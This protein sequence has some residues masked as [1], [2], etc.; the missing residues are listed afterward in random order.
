M[1]KWSTFFYSRWFLVGG[2]I[3]IVFLVFSVGRSFYQQN[4]IAHQIAQLEMQAKEL[5]TKKLQTLELLQYARSTNFVEE[6]ARTELHLMKPGEH[7]MVVKNQDSPDKNRQ[8]EQNMVSSSTLSN[9]Q[10]WYN[11]FF[12]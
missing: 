2:A 1:S 11:Y 12:N 6:K 10:K 4:E 9:T 7:V 3:L 5:E 8:I